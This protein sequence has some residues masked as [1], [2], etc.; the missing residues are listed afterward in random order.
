[1]AKARKKASTRAKASKAKAGKSNGKARSTT[2]V[3]KAFTK[4]EL[5]MNLSESTGLGKKE[6]GTLFADL[7]GIVERH[8]KKQAVGQ[9][10]LPGLL[11]IKTRK[12]PAKKAR[13]NVPNPF[14]PGELMDVKAK[15]ACIK[16]KILPLKG[17]KS[18]V[19]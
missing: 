5:L 17:L 19:N 2:A 6:I 15:P 16:V 13:K 7:A 11:K 12:I 3:K 18:M 4:T 1:M 10:T 14:K 8:V 9:F